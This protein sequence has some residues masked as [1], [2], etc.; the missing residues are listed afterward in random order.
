[1]ADANNVTDSG[2]AALLG[3]LNAQLAGLK[4]TAQD[5][6]MEHTVSVSNATY[7]K[8]SRP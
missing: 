4:A 1:M 8:S 3:V 2:A 5:V 7:S 6:M